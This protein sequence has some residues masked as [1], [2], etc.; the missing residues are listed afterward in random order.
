MANHS[1]ESK[2]GRV[3]LAG[4]SGFL[5]QE[6]SDALK[7]RGYEPIVL[8]RST[9]SREGFVAWDGKNLGPWAARLDG[10]LA[11][12]NLTGKSVDCRNTP[13]NRRE[14]IDSRVDS[15][16]VLGEAWRRC[17]SP[18]SIWIQASSLAIYG[19]PGD[20]VCTEDS[21]HGQGFSVEICKRWEGALE[22]QNLGSTRRVIQRI[23]FVLAK[24]KGALKRLAPL[25]RMFLGGTVGNG[26]QYIS[27]LH[28]EDLCRI[29]VA[30]LEDSRMSGPYNVTGPN[31]V[32]NAQFMAA[33]RRALH[34]PWS[35]PA[36]TLAVKI[37]AFFMGTDPSLALT[38][39][40]CL[41]KR[42]LEQG[43]EFHHT[44]LN[45]CLETLYGRIAA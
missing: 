3:I 17:Q 29:F 37:G 38:G 33:L 15:V 2:R 9:A 31:P 22:N 35:P 43:F 10:A 8:T 11:I 36:P 30:A 12:I 40:R 27:W 7:L 34:R 14:I 26:S 39:R 16:N 6:L 20:Q 24:D 5:G 28:I 25:T 18:P 19:D 42:L 41:P 21:P 44:E 23:G 45:A 32:T 13:D 4:G 1:G